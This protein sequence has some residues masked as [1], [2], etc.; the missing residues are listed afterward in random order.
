MANIARPLD[1]AAH[2][3]SVAHARCC[4]LAPLTLTLSYALNFL[5]RTIFN[6]LIEPIN[7]D[8]PALKQDARPACWF[9]LRADVFAARPLARLA[10][11][12]RGL[13]ES[14]PQ[15]HIWRA[16]CQRAQS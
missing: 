11:A 8:I 6:V 14:M 7:K 12:A 16:R 4:T 15:R 9:L 5:D 1:A 13:A 2:A 10:A 3:S